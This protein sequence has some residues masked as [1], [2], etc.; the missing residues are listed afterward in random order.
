[1]KSGRREASH[2]LVTELR[3]GVRVG[4]QSPP[5]G[6]ARDLEHGRVVGHHEAGVGGQ[7]DAVQLEDED[8]AEVRRWRSTVRSALIQRTRQQI[9]A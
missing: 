6:A 8:R 9:S 5:D 7:D 3:S 4:S 2:S 1:M